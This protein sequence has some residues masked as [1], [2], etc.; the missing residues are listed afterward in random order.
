MRSNTKI[1]NATNLEDGYTIAKIADLANSSSVQ[2]SSGPAQKT[3]SS[4]L[5][6][7]SQSCAGIPA[8]NN[9]SADADNHKKILAVGVGVGIGVG[10]PL[11]AALV[12]AL[13]LLRRERRKSANAAARI[14]NVNGYSM[15][16]REGFERDITQHI[17]QLHE[18]DSPRLTDRSRAVELGEEDRIEHVK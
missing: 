18:M 7:P 1:V 5:P 6:T 8:P 16:G 11:L 12:G 3:Q 10:V 15:V 4:S 13:V 9:K 2:S 17:G 14:P